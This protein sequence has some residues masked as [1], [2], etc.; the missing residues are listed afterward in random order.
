MTINAKITSVTPTGG[1]NVYEISYY[2]ETAPGVIIGVDDMNSGGKVGD[3]AVKNTIL[4]KCIS[5]DTDMARAGNVDAIQLNDI[6]SAVSS[7]WR[8]VVCSGIDAKV[9]A[10]AIE[11]GT[12]KDINEEKKLAVVEVYMIVTDTLYNRLYLVYEDKD[13]AFKFEQIVQ[14]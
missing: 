9:A 4:D 6:F 2:E 5:L 7:P 14:E 10:G 12:I 11:K 3:L 1:G 8:A 13:Q